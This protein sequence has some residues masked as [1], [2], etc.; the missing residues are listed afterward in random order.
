[1]DKLPWEIH[2]DLTEERLA[3]LARLIRSVRAD[4]VDAHDPDKGDTSWGLGCRSHERT[5]FAIINAAAGIASSWLSV[6][7]PGLHFV[8]A[9]GSVPL[10]FYR[11]EAEHPPTKSL[12]RN[13]AEIVQ[14]QTSMFSLPGFATPVRNDLRAYLWRIAIETN[15]DGSVDRVVLV[16]VSEDGQSLRTIHEI[17]ESTVGYV[18]AT[19]PKRK[20][21]KPLPPPSVELKSKKKNKKA[22]D[23]ES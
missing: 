6:I 3:F 13:Y 23:N 15:F 19:E 4:A 8:F 20:E 14:A 5:L 9:V 12:Q 1:M 11:G 2:P 7:E 21:G 10:R 18:A 22:D 17:P 16:E